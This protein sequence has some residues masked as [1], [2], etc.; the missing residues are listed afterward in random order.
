MTLHYLVAPAGWPNFGDELIAA[1]WLRHLAEVAPEAQVVLDC[2]NPA[3]LALR[4]HELHPNVRV[5]DTLWQVVLRNWHEGAEGAVAMA[6]WAIANPAQTMDLAEGIE[7]LRRADTIHLVGGGFIN[8]LWPPFHG[9][10]AG[11]VAAAEYSGATTAMTGQ[12]LCPPLGGSPQLVRDL[13][14]GFA[15]VDVRDDPSAELLAGL[16][17]SST[18]DDAFLG[19]S[20]NVLPM[21][22]SCPEVI[23]SAQIE[24]GAIDAADLIDFL[25][26]TV[27]AWQVTEVGVLECS[28][29]GDSEFIDLVTRSLPVKRRYT[30]DD[31]LNKGFPAAPGQTWLSTR[32]H[33][34]LVAAA[35]GAGG[36]ALNVRD[37]AYYTTKHR[38]LIELGSGWELIVPGEVPLRP[39]SGGFS[40]ESLAKVRSGKLE[41]ARQIYS[42]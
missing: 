12:G 20:G 2:S 36:V 42:G 19:V 27:E 6:R 18:G 24:H 31:A 17:V 10:L 11:I 9:L 25:R 13:A 40:A 33:P 23:I 32:F 3:T 8:D 21:D 22:T 15:I 5:V 26:R 39:T 1:S 14:A 28:P 7:L 41:V 38:S 34:H 35:A 37:D 16:K 30:V 29:K 4:P